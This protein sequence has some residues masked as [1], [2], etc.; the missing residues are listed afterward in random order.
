MW[1]WRLESN[2]AWYIY[3]L[4]SL[5]PELRIKKIKLEAKSDCDVWYEVGWNFENDMSSREQL[6]DWT[7]IS[8]KIGAVMIFMVFF[9][10]FSFF[11]FFQ[12]HTNKNVDET[13]LY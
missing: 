11:F 5:V 12:E 4:I 2:F 1:C 7:Y 3:K 13:M 8:I 9:L 10:F 6:E